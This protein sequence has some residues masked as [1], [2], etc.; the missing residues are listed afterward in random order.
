VVV[1][2][3]ES[4][5]T[6]AEMEENLLIEREKYLAAGV[7]IGTKSSHVDMEE[8]IFRV[9]KN[10]LAVLD[11]E[12]TDER[13]R[14]AA[15]FISQFDPENVLVVGRKEIAFNPIELFSEYTGA[16]HIIGRFTPGTLTNPKAQDFREPEVVVVT[17][18][19]QDSQVVTEAAQTN[20]PVVAFCDS[21]D[22]L[23]NID[24]PIP[25]NNKGE[26]AIATVYYL[27]TKQ[28]L[29][30]RGVEVELDVE[31]FQPEEDEE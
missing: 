28:I 14:E 6:Q 29:E 19:E 11:L 15:E 20:V 21:G 3:T 27:L 31:E 18:P 25:A 5:Q 17:D 10:Q 23:D 8:F 22:S 16:E 13:I 7:H 24:Y 1:T 26:K 12:Q 2:E 30:E 9:K 4:Q